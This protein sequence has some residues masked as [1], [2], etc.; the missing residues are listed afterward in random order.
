MCVSAWVIAPYRRAGHGGSRLLPRSPSL[1]HLI[2]LFYFQLFFG[3]GNSAILAGA[4]RVPW[5]FCASLASATMAVC[6]T[7]PHFFPRNHFCS[8]VV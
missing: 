2:L 6:R 5:L 1:V 8:I 3:S 7:I 4:L